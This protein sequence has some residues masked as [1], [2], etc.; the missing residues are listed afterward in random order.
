MK[1]EGERLPLF[2]LHVVGVWLGDGLEL[3]AFEHRLVGLTHQ[4]LER[5][6]LNFVGESFLDDGG[7]RF[8]G[9]E[10]G[11]ADLAGN[12]PGSPLFGVGYARGRDRNLK[13]ALDP[14]GL[15]GG[16]FDIHGRKIT[17]GGRQVAGVFFGILPAVRRP[18][19][20]VYECESRE[21]NPDGLPHR[22]LSP[23]RLPVPPLSRG[24]KVLIQKQVTQLSNKSAWHPASH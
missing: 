12:A 16:D 21:S 9:P 8:A 10:T 1:L 23:A 19:S 5:F 7:G 20:V 2:E 15:S 14:F 13:A 4:R 22:I 6:L 18:P 11:E 3:L 17:D 24:W